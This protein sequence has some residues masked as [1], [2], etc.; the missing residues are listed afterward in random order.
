MVFGKV[1]TKEDPQPFCGEPLRQRWFRKVFPL[2]HRKNAPNPSRTKP[3][4]RMQVELRGEYKNI[5]GCCP[6]LGWLRGTRAQHHLCVAVAMERHETFTHST[7]PVRRQNRKNCQELSWLVSSLEHWEFSW[8]LAVHLRLDLERSL[9]FIAGN[10]HLS[11]AAT[12]LWT[13]GTPLCLTIGQF[14]FRF[15]LECVF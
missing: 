5:T 7:P 13:W 3:R 8:G 11:P 10:R 14:G 15:S 2:V 1:L 12:P 6:L 4:L 9:M